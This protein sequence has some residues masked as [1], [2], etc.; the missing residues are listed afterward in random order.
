MPK[1][2]NAIASTIHIP[3][4]T[5]KIKNGINR[6]NEASIPI[7]HTLK[8]MF[9]FFLL[10]VNS[11]APFVKRKNELYANKPKKITAEML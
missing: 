1:K 4:L 5:S 3:T 11:P 8:I 6:V 2:I 10:G 9:L 7:P